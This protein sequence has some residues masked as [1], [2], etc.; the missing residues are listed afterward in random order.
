[1]AQQEKWGRMRGKNR[2]KIPVEINRGR[3]EKGERN[4]KGRGNAK[5]KKAPTSGQSLFPLV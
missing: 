3:K 1:M 5:K 4:R 2:K